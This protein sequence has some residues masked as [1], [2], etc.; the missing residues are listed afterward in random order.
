[1]VQGTA[2]KVRDMRD[3]GGQQSSGTEE[4][5][6][7]DPVTARRPGGCTWPSRGHRGRGKTGRGRPSLSSCRGTL[8][9]PTEGII[10][11]PYN[12]A[13]AAWRRRGPLVPR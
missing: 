10:S 9:S 1:M 6:R 12:L 8:V 3:P 5:C 4:Q 7:S 11:Q 13:P 2:E